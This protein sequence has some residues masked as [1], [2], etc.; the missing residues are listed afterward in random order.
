[1]ARVREYTGL[2]TR[3]PRQRTN[4]TPDELPVRVRATVGRG[5]GRYRPAARR[6]RSAPAN[7]RRPA[8]TPG[9]RPGRPGRRRPL[10][11]RPGPL[12]GR[13]PRPAGSVQARP[14]GAR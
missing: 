10:A 9:V 4:D 7:A 1:M 14:A 11:D 13:L 8:G 5:P 6:H 3:D 12:A 2:L